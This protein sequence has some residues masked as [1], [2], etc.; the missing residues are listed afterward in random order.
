[1]LANDNKPLEKKTT[2]DEPSSSTEEKNNTTKYVSIEDDLEFREFVESL[3]EQKRLQSELQRTHPRKTN[4]TNVTPLSNGNQR[5]SLN[6]NNFLLHSN[7]D[8]TEN[9]S[10]NEIN[11]NESLTTVVYA[12]QSVTNLQ[13]LFMEFF[14]IFLEI[15]GDC[16]WTLLIHMLCRPIYNEKQM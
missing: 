12:D 3:L 6:T 8:Q 4:P 11:A 10:L 5:R 13:Y 9:N 16:H 15:V 7:N 14:K 1:M 2:N